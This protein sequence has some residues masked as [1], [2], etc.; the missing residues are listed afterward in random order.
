MIYVN[1]LDQGFYVSGTHSARHVL[2]GL[3]AVGHFIGPL[4][5]GTEPALRAGRQRRLKAPFDQFRVEIGHTYAPS[6]V[7]V[8]NKKGF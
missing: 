1:S 3:H 4:R 8:L 2:Q 7:T 5:R 6:E